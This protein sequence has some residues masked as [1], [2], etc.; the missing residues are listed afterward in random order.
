VE[1]RDALFVGDHPE[2]DYFGPSAAGMRAVLV[3]ARPVEGVP[4]HL[5]VPSILQLGDWIGSRW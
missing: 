1:P 4:E 5:R 3:S 2:C